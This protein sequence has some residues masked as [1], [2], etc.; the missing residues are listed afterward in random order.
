MIG[1]D[2]K[3]KSVVVSQSLS[4]SVINKNDIAVVQIDFD[5]KLPWY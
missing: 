2:E 4:V 5:L 3:S 1:M